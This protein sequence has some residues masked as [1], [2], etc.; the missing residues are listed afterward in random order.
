MTGH[1]GGLRAALA[2]LPAGQP[3]AAWPSVLGLAL[4]PPVP[5]C[6]LSFWGAKE[7]P[8]WG[9]SFLFFFNF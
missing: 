7:I 4:C 9:V 8:L 3:P 6:L 1:S 5:E 2:S